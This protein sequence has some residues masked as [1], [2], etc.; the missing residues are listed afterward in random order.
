MVNVTIVTINETP[1]ML[2]IGLEFFFKS[3]FANEKH[4][5][6]I[7]SAIFDYDFYMKHNS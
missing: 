7:W 5:F 6:W 2:Q 4:I 3:R 1:E